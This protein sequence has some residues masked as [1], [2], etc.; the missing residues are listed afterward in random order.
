MDNIY[1]KVNKILEK[2]IDTKK[3]VERNTYEFYNTLLMKL[4]NGLKNENFVFDHELSTYVVA[5]FANKVIKGEEFFVVD[6]L[7][8][9]KFEGKLLSKKLLTELIENHPYSVLYK[10]DDEV[11]LSQTNFAHLK[12]DV[13][14][15]RRLEKIS[16]DETLKEFIK[17]IYKNNERYNSVRSSKKSFEENFD[18]DYY[19]NQTDEFFMKLVNSV[20]D[21][22]LNEEDLEKK[23]IIMDVEGAYVYE[24][25]DDI[26]YMY[27]MDKL[28]RVKV[29]YDSEVDNY[30]VV[31][32]R[33][34]ELI[35]S[36]DYTPLFESYIGKDCIHLE[37]TLENIKNYKSS[38]EK[39]KQYTKK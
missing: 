1:E 27:S 28:C 37:T 32:D 30:I 18:K 17:E 26:E 8:Y 23:I 6:G 20:L 9:P 5:S 12:A 22:F 25:N 21:G 33:L 15:V 11:I 38:L 4:L 39:P 7:C 13:E 3:E 29:L 36:S 19:M 10:K 31:L 14:G 35:Q 2:G 24:M 34:I 16:K